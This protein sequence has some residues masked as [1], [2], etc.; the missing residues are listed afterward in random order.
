MHSCDEKDPISEAF[1]WD[2]AF[3]IRVNMEHA[4]VRAAASPVSV[5][6]RII[7]RAR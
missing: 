5:D 2:V 6:L 3:E 4:R 7:A 1:G